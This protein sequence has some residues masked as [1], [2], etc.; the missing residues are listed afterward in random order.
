[1]IT[2]YSN[3]IYNKNTILVFSKSIVAQKLNV[4]GQEEW[5]DLIYNYCK[6]IGRAHV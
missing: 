3:E 2:N 5:Q 6:E 4:I 1:M